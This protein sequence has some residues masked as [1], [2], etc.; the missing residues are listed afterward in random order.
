MVSARA[1]A[2]HALVSLEKGKHDRLRDVLDAAR[3]QG[4]DQA[5][6]YEL[7][8]GA[9]RRERLLDHVL[10]GLAHRGL[11]KDPALRCALRLGAYQL[12][13]VD[14]MPAHAAVDETVALARSNKG[15]VN[16]I[17][18]R[19]AERV[20]WSEADA[21]TIAADVLRLGPRR[22]LHLPQALPTGAVERLAVLHSLPVFLLERWR[23]EHGE[24]ALDQLAAAAT[25]VPPVW[26]RPVDSA[27]IAELQQQ[28][29]AG[30]VETALAEDG[31][32]LR[33]TGGESPFLSEA[34][35][36]GRFF[37]Q[38]PTAWRA[39]MAVPCAP[40]DLAIDLCA[41]PG[42]KTAVLA[43]RVQPGGRVFAFDV[44]E[45]R[46]GR[47]VENAARLRL[48]HTIELA[49]SIDEL[50]PAAAVL[51][52]VPCSNTG[53]LGRRVEVRRRLD[54]GTFAR[55]AAVQREL[56]AQ[57]LRLVRPGGH[58]VYSTCSIDGEENDD[59]VAAV[60]AAH[61]GWERVRR[62]LTLPCAG[63]HDGGYFA[64]LAAGATGS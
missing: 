58:V 40:G 59:V 1:A 34:Y 25:A 36:T 57:A 18:R 48:E 6:A 19:L 63:S 52:D 53:V 20:D 35:G 56:L 51:V 62:E 37:V 49:A 27:A 2:L 7:A 50:P 33:W 26:L 9:V 13:F 4:R 28:F 41:A 24:H 21:N 16:A 17:L 29:A 42:T 44:D 55:L 10:G 12:L 31:S 30:G 11:P 14:G 8:H 22:V 60:L 39:A 61:P 46:R 47:I 5:L 38:D 43:A 45:R 64:V 23:R 3:L 32:A 15:F 54:E